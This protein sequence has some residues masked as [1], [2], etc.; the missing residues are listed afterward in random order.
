MKIKPLP[1]DVINKIAAGEIVERPASVLKELIENSIDA[2]ATKI[3]VFIEKAG[4]REITVVDNGEGIEKEDL[5]N[6][7]KRHY[8]SKIKAEE[9]LFNII[10]FGFR[11]EAL[12]SISAVSK[13]K[14][15]SRTKNSLVGNQIYIEGGKLLN[16]SEMG[17]S[18]GTK[19]EV[20][21]LFFNT[22]A[23]EK[24]LKSDNTENLHIVTTFIKYALSNP[25][26]H[27]K[28]YNENKEIF[29]LYP[30]DLEK[31]LKTIYNEDFFKKL[32]YVE[33]EN[34][35]GKIYGYISLEGEISKRKY[36]FIN[37]RPVKNSIV[38]N[39]IKKKIG[40]G[41]YLLFIEIPPYMVD[42]NIHPSKE[43]VKFRK[44]SVV[45]NL[46]DGSFQKQ[47]NQ[48]KT[49]V[50]SFQENYL[51]QNKALYD[52][53]KENFEIIGQIEDTFIIAYY[54]KEVYFIDQH[55]ANERVIFEILKNKLEEKN[56]INSQRLIS[57]RLISPMKVQLTPEQKEM[58]KVISND[59]EKIGFLLEESNGDFYI[60][61]V[62]Y[63]L[64]V[65][66]SITLLY[67]LLEKGKE[68]TIDSILSSLSCR[69]SI[70]AGDRLTLEEAKEILKMWI[71]TENPNICPH[72]RPIYYKIHIDEI[73]KVV[74]RL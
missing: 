30:S 59:L 60:K 10:S 16:F 24:F 12:S 22:P 31:R 40:D 38:S 50:V 9:D 67:E 54:N 62:P 53:E 19:V 13:I 20:K 63:N 21:N 51:K 17:A 56:K 69:M 64:P 32:K 66:K 61:G 1:E 5:L 3:E 14:I 34:H 68:I 49:S 45:L 23:R 72:G 6:A 48:F 41:F 26:I 27:F 52:P 33:Y 29:N 57:Q 43:E 37:K 65:E 44:E 74:N 28:L 15:T 46:I 39:Y 8:T 58:V 36:L 55:V 73:K 4:K 18:I 47:L 25:S 2:N 7:V 11:G 70:T 71:K 42:V 35:L